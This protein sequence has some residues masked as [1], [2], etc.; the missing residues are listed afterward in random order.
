MSTSIQ[1]PLMAAVRTILVGSAPL[2]ALLGGANRVFDN[3]SQQ[4][5][6]PYISFGEC[7]TRDWSSH[8]NEGFQG[9]LQLDTW[10]STKHSRKDCLLIQ[11]VIYQLLHRKPVVVATFSQVVFLQDLQTAMKDEDGVTYHGISRFNFI[12]GGSEL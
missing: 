12:F 1:L 2:T 11:D 8:T 4:H 3:P 9:S 6:P 5:E 10:T 7:V